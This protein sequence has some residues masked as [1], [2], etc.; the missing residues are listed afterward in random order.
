MVNNLFISLHDSGFDISAIFSGDPLQY[1]SKFSLSKT[2]TITLMRCN[3]DENG[4]CL[5][6]PT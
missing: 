4:N 3:D 5:T 6:I 1:I 2:L